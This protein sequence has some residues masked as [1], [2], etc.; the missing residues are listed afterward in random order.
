MPDSSDESRQ[1]IVITDIRVPFSSLL[2]LVFKVSMA[3][4]PSLVVLATMGVLAWAVI[5]LALNP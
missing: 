2:E 1:E 3:A 5:W 4:I